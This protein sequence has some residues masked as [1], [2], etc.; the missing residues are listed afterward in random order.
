MEKGSRGSVVKELEFGSRVWRRWRCRRKGHEGP[1]GGV[2]ESR[3]GERETS[4]TF[5]PSFFV[6]LS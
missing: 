3:G 1:G 6:C 2:K 4:E 5:F